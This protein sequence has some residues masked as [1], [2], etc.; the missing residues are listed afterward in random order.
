MP[1]ETCGAGAEA[2]KTGSTWH[3][4]CCCSSRLGLRIF[5][6]RDGG[7][8]RVGR[9]HRDRGDGNRGAVQFAEWEDWVALVAGALMIISPWALGFAAM[10]YAAGT[11]AVLG[12][13]VA[14]ASVS[15]IWMVH[16]RET[17]LRS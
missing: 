3:A 15:E 12:V 9:R 8:D 14:L 7:E 5:R 1:T 11:M 16:H 10:H 13:I 17:A 4:A 6:G 2:Y